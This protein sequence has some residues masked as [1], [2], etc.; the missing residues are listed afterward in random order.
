MPDHWITILV[1]AQEFEPCFRLEFKWLFLKIWD[2]NHELEPD[3][4]EKGKC[5]VEHQDVP[6]FEQVID[7]PRQVDVEQYEEQNLRKGVD[8]RWGQQDEDNQENRKC[9]DHDDMIVKN[10]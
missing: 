10:V 9:N 2:C 7:A 6:K 8:A 4:A 3:D 1:E 5:L